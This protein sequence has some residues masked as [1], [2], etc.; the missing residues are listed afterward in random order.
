MTNA[1]RY[2]PAGVLYDILF[3]YLEIRTIYKVNT[4]KTITLGAIWIFVPVHFRGKHVI[5]T[6]IDSKVAIESLVDNQSFL[7]FGVP[8]KRNNLV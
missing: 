1:R 6:G 3:F 2:R 4:G 8:C 5:W 7:R